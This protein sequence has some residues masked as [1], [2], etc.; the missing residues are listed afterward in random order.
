MRVGIPMIALSAVHHPDVFFKHLLALIVLKQAVIM[1]KALQE[2]TQHGGAVGLLAAHLNERNGIWRIALKRL[3]IDVQ[4]DAD[5]A[6][7]DCTAAKRVL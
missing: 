2:I 5:D 6:A 3:L 1:L 7:T 4:A